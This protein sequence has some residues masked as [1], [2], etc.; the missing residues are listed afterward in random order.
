[1][2]GSADA[3]R[4]RPSLREL[5]DKKLVGEGRIGWHLD[6][7]EAAVECTMAGIALVGQFGVGLAELGGV[8]MFDRVSYRLHLLRGKFR[9]ASGRIEVLRLLQTFF[10]LVELVARQSPVAEL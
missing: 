2:T 3:L 7:N 4:E 5:I 1:M 6:C 9:S 10:D 8:A